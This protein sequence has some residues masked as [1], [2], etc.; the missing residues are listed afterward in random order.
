MAAIDSVLSK[1]RNLINRANSTTGRTDADL[2]NAVDA[3]IDGYGKGGV[4]PSGTK[5]ITANGNYDVT[6]YA[7]ANVN[8]PASGVT[9]SGTKTITANGTH[10]VTSYASANVSVPTGMNAKVFTTTVASDVTSGN[11]KLLSANT[12]LASI[13]SNPNAFVLAVPLNQKASTAMYS[14]WIIANFV[15]AYTGKSARKAL[16][17]RT[18]TSANNVVGYGGGVSGTNGTGHLEMA[19]DGSLTVK[20]CNTT[21]PLR[22]GEYL[23]IAG[24]KEML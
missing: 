9:P 13:R 20:G 8:V 23:I 4:T 11:Y 24:L 22:A 6:E 1:I 10:D 16:C 18:S 3:L 5:T 15:L 7:Q 17:V 2:T 12:F 21:Y 19:S 14:L